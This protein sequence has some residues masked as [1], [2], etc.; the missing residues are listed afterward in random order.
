MARKALPFRWNLEALE[1]RRL[2]SAGLSGP[3]NRQAQAA[4][5]LEATRAVGTP[6]AELAIAPNAGLAATA[7]Q[8]RAERQAQQQLLREQR[9]LLQQQKL[10]AQVYQQQI[11]KQLRAQGK[12]LS[13][14]S[15]DNTT[16]LI[17]LKQ[18][19]G[20]RIDDAAMYQI[21]GLTVDQA[22]A[23][24]GG[25]SVVL[26]TSSQADAMYSLWMGIPRRAGA[27]SP[28]TGSARAVGVGALQTL[29]KIA[30]AG[31]P[32]VIS[33]STK[34]PLRVVSATSTSNTEAIVQF[35]EPLSDRAL[36]AQYYEIT[37]DKVNPE[38]GRLIV[39]NARF[40][41]FGAANGK[42]VNRSTVV[43]TTE[44]QNE[45]DY[46]V[47]VANVVDLDGTPLAGPFG[48]AGVLIDPTTARFQGTPPA[49]EIKNGVPT[50]VDT[51]GD[52]LSD[53]EEQRGW[54]VTVIAADGT[55][56]TRTVTSDIRLADT[57]GDGLS[58]AQEF[59]LH[60]D[61]R[62]RDT[63]GDQLNDFAEFNE[64]FSNGLSQDTDGD[65]I[66]D[67]AEFTFFKTSPVFADSDGDQIGDGD[68]INGNRNPLVADLPRPEVEVGAINL[69][70]DVRFSESN[71]EESRDLETRSVSSM[72]QQSESRSLSRQSTVAL[73]AKLSSEA[74]YEDGAG[75]FKIGVEASAGYTFQQTDESAR[76]TQ[77]S[78]E[79][80]LASEREVTNGFT[81]DREVVGASLQA[82]V[83]L[84]NLSNLAYRVKNLQVTAF[85]QDPQ[86][87]SRLTPVATL[88]PDIEP[89]DGFTLGPLVTN[90]GPLIFSNTTIVP[91]LVESLMR[92]TS[93]LVFRI[94]NYDIVNEDGRNFAFV[95]Q[96]VV[97]RTAGL[98]IDFGGARSLRAQ[99]SDTP[100]DENLPGDETEI[101][102]VSTAQGRTIDTNGDGAIDESDRRATFDGAGKEVGITLFDALAAVGLTRFE[103]RLD[104]ATGRYLDYLP[105]AS[106]PVD[107]S[108]PTEANRILNS[109]S[110]YEDDQGREK[111]FRIRGVSN[112]FGIKKFW[113]ILTPLGIDQQT[114][115]GDLVLKS[116]APASLNFVQDLDGDGLTADVEY[117]LRTSDSPLDLLTYDANGR[118]IPGQDGVPDG[119]DT[120]GDGLDDRFEALIGWTVS[121][122]LRTYP[123]F[124]SPNRV[125]SNFDAPLPGVD[126]DQDGVEDRLE[127]DGSDTFAAPAGWDDKNGNGLRDRFEVFGAGPN[128][129]VLDPIRR[130]TDTDGIDDAVEIVGFQITRIETGLKQLIPRTDPLTPFSDSDTFTDGFEKFV[131]LDP[132]DGSDTDA[133]GDGLPD[134]VELAGWA[135]GKNLVNVSERQTLR[136]SY[137]VFPRR[138]V[139][140][141]F[142]LQYG[143][144]PST[145][146]N[147]TAPLDGYTSILS[148]LIAQALNDLPA[149]RNQ[150]GVIT[151]EQFSNNTADTIIKDYTITFGGGLVGKDQPQLI[152]TI[153]TPSTLL[154]ASVTTIEQGRVDRQVEGVSLDPYQ[155]GPL[156][157]RIGKSRTDSADSDGDGLTDYEEFFLHTDPSSIDT[158]GDGLDD[159]SE[160]LGYSL[161]HPVDGKDLGLIKTDPL[162]ADTDND[163]RSDGAEAERQDIEL[164]RWVVRVGGSSAAG[165]KGATA[166]RV[167]S[168]PLIADADFDGLVDGQEFLARTDPNN[169]NTDGDLR[170]DGVEFRSGT[171]PL[172]ADTRVTVVVS[173]LEAPAGLTFDVQLNVRAPDSAGVGGLSDALKPVFSSNNIQVGRVQLYSRL[174]G[175]TKVR[176]VDVNGIPFQAG[177]APATDNQGLGFNG[178]KTYDPGQNGVPLGARFRI[179]SDN[180]ASGGLGKNI[181]S[182][183]VFIYSAN[184]KIVARIRVGDGI[185]FQG[186]Y[187]FDGIDNQIAATNPGS[188]PLSGRSFSFGLADLERFS[189]EGVITTYDGGVV[190]TN[191]G[192]LEGVKA[193]QTDSTNNQQTSVRP[194]FSYLQVA[195]KYLEEFSFVTTGGQSVKLGFY[196][197][198]G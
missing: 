193:N 129:L 153:V 104:P 139:Q 33:P 141:L 67:F 34:E 40:Q 71:A 146:E 175:E 26:K 6:P 123:V 125:D 109:Y 152:V 3:H 106:T 85:V 178:T 157:S 158:D 68:E 138:P 39:K 79:N 174:G 9:Q 154:G 92:N 20:R 22:I 133:D 74:G 41:E 5:N 181:L 54:Q 8:T 90:R 124:S 19:L 64:I 2:M 185:N 126:S 97:D 37:P 170:D 165:A 13:A 188:V 29:G 179:V 112:D 119:R 63:D 144:G 103:A 172:A 87:R 44:S 164:N 183:E 166:Y 73:E 121:T 77:Q 122:S 62:S 27:N 191:F 117:L 32:P 120:D 132:N 7:Q 196:Y 189:I 69:Q 102:R 16:I 93:G 177:F 96:D 159:R 98:T 167:Y 142:T 107:T 91:S 51:D 76:E 182:N 94:S 23:M 148:P 4:A 192:G 99:V 137:V 143:A 89:E 187:A 45:I 60:F 111:V 35:S 118:R 14:Q 127:Y 198:I 176:F 180:T 197:L 52:G 105:G 169:A 168:N 56:T 65:G 10:L 110:T 115:L 162:D 113:E 194:V 130:D 17:Q 135:V 151:A 100:I 186:S 11:Q 114:E 156:A 82:T 48:F 53:N 149:I 36:V 150:G 15:L 18:R 163:M 21:P 173:T 24:P 86:D 84:R 72:L 128:D 75:F 131:G 59:N 28:A 161:G 12:I 58:D 95:S 57:D 30:V 83:S 160:V 70:L 1:D 134:K 80:S 190:K 66:D 184:S 81:V 38:S 171:N 49:A 43:L 61:P 116:S 140:F 42:V 31:T 108:L 78:Y 88:L 47:R 50:L 145:P 46:T 147:T 195:D 101:H 55:T 136:A 155:P 25:K